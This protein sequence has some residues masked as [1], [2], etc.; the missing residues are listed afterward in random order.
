[1]DNRNDTNIYKEVSDLNIEKDRQELVEDA[2]T[3]SW[4][5]EDEIKETAD[6]VSFDVQK[7]FSFF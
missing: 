4:L 6:P 7:L 3:F 1:M 2:T 5:D